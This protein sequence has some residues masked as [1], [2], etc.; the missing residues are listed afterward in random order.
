[1]K[2]FCC[3]GTRRQ[4]VIDSDLNGID[5]LDV[6]DDPTLSDKKR[7]ERQRLLVVHLLKPLA[8]GSM[9]EN[10]IRIQGGHGIRDIRV[11]KV[12]SGT[13][14]DFGLL[15]TDPSKILI[16]Q[17]DRPGDFSLYTLSLVD[18]AK[19][20]NPLN[21]PEGFDPV[22]SS[23]SFSFKVNCLFDL[24]CHK[25][26]LC[27]PEGEIEPEI[28]YLAKDYASFRQLM[29][30]RLALIIPG[31]KER[32]PADLGIAMVEL[33]AYVGDYLSYRQDAV[34]TEAYLGTARG[35]VSV[36]RH[37]R[38]VDYF[39]NDGC[40]SR[41]W[42]QI[43]VSRE[44]TIQKGTELLTSLKDLPLRIGSENYDQ[45]LLQNPVIF[46]A[47]HDAGLFTAHN[48]IPFYTWGYEQCCLPKGATKATLCDDL[49][50]RRLLM[51]GDVLIFEEAKG[52][53]SGL[54]E[55]ADPTRRHAVRIT[56]VN[57]SAMEIKGNEMESPIRQPAAPVMDPL[58]GS[59]IVE[60]E[61]HEEDALPF[62]LCISSRGK[63]AI[64]DVSVARGNV[65]LADQGQTIHKEPLGKV[66]PSR[67]WLV[68]SNT[69]DRCV[70]VGLQPIHPRFWPRLSSGP[71]TFAHPYKASPELS[72]RSAINGDGS[73]ALPEIF[74]SADEDLQEQWLPALD[75][76]EVDGSE[77]RFVV[78]V[79]RDGSAFLRFGD[80]RHG[81]HP[82]SGTGFY[83]TYRVGN[84]LRG[85]VGADVIVHIVSNDEALVSVRN[86]MPASG[87]IDP[88]SIEEVRQS[89]PSAFRVQER[90]VTEED[91][92]KVAQRHPQVQRAVATIR[93]TGSWY[94]V[95]LTIDRLGG[96]DVD[97]DF[98][99]EMHNHL[100][101]YRMAG[102][103][104]EIEGPRL[105]PLEIDMIAYLK[106]GYF[107]VDIRAELDILFSSSI[108]P[109]GHR[110]LFHP[111][112]F[113]LGQPVYLSRLYQAA[114]FVEGIERAEITKFQ[115][116]FDDSKCGIVRGSLT[117]GRLEVACLDND[118]N[119][120][121]RG[122][123]RLKIME[124]A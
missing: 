113:T 32:N 115:R 75:L 81:R 111:D 114:M 7:L 105:V 25:D 19:I 43:Q 72:A 46:E 90:A 73:K 97:D 16:V 33:L 102:H 82:T 49:Q 70:E 83:A 20:Q 99:E 30:D 89:A 108:L 29:L 18:S 69:F 77:K 86:P 26:R 123:F 119:F 44:T 74:L 64:S 2:Y 39:I 118:P 1:M 95:F 87:G 65:I 11:T 122:I 96:W 23:V 58:T 27:P 59:S 107:Q 93:W 55:D 38:L 76:L 6:P 88:E 91:Y 68:R 57:P 52:P 28:S 56:R 60:I 48:E 35:R 34:A 14:E 24:D 66:P 103:D 109:D 85:N 120:P 10:N 79:E 104:V 67:P 41:V 84:G 15:F 31:W 42:I 17:V 8:I 36:R 45:A 3:Q 50:A 124:A 22:L 92:A 106:Q 121:D 9:A 37:A 78:E 61:W 4:A 71:L 63:N 13:Q 101:M 80:D 54:A 47:Q 53:N 110:G 51:P 62:P 117:I 12:V 40:N 98:K 112:N 100:E 116:L 21:S 5:F 94:T